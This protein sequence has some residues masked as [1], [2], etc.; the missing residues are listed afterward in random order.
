[1]TAIGLARHGCDGGKEK[2]DNMIRSNWR[3]RPSLLCG[4]NAA[5][6]SKENGDEEGE[7]AGKEERC[8]EESLEKARRMFGACAAAAGT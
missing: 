7:E 4:E 1:M 3:R 8:G 5:A 2:T 6:T